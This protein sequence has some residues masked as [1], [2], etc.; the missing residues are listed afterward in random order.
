MAHRSSDCYRPV[1]PTL[2][3]ALQMEYAE[4]ANA[5]YWKVGL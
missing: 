2:L 1:A 4:R 5:A 3:T